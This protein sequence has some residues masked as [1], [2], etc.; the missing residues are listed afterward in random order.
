MVIA[1][2][3]IAPCAKAQLGAPA[4]FTQPAGPVLFTNAT[5]NGMVW[6]RGNPTFAW[7]EWGP[8]TRYGNATAPVSANGA[9]VA[10]VSG[11][12]PDL[13]AGGV[14]HCRLVASNSL[15]GFDQLFTTGMKV[16]NWGGYPYGRP[17]IPAGLT[18]LVGV[19]AGHG[20]CL[21]LRNDG[22]VAAWIVGFSYPDHGQTNV[23]AG[24][25]NVVAIAG[26]FSDSL[27]VKADGTV[28]A[29]GNY[30]ADVPKP[31]FLTNVVVVASGFG[32][33]EVVK[34]DGTLAAWGKTIDATNVP[35]GLSNVVAFASG[36]DH[37]VGLAPVDLPPACFPGSR[38][39]GTN[40]DLTLALPVYDPNGDEL[41]VRS[42][43][44]PVRGSLF[45]YTDNGRGDPII[46]AGTIL[47]NPPR[48]IFA[49]DPATFGV[50]YAGI[51]FS[52]ADGEYQSDP[53]SYSISVMPPPI[54]QSAGIS[55]TPRNALSLTFAGLSGGNYAVL[56]SS[57]FGTWTYLGKAIETT[58]GEFS[59]TD[60]AVTNS[61]VGF[62]RVWAY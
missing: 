1:M 58:S 62:Y 17:V 23:P 33:G 35:P 57:A 25:S 47:T 32:Y 36:D 19:A 41:T 7:F 4:A 27:A 38:T 44:L 52:A 51:G 31:A 56:R 6:P 54:I 49:P 22:T 5:L 48:V 21:A 15:Y 13:A 53:A 43:S 3:T 37:C 10:R 46:A 11:G 45:Q 9:S 61:P 55:V 40:Q 26:G 24:L 18:N 29:W 42:T 14:Y 16:Q 20:H 59:F 2:A 50:G 60:Y 12:I 34:A 28:V 30:N 8:D 39:G